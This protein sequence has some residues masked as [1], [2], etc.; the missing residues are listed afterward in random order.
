[1]AGCEKGPPRRTLRRFFLKLLEVC[2]SCYA[3]ILTAIGRGTQHRNNPAGNELRRCQGMSPNPDNAPARFAKLPVH[4][5]I[6]SNISL[7]LSLPIFLVRLRHAAVGPATMPKTPV[8]E[9]SNTLPS[10]NEIRLPR[11]IC[12]AT[13]AADGVRT[14]NRN[15]LQLSCFVAVRTYCSHYL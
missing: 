11:K 6:T 4:A 3:G 14:Q 5:A 2:Q 1:M 13:P 10:K 15:Q 12:T 9:N 7:N 8:N